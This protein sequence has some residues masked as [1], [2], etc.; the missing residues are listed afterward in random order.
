MKKTYAKFAFMRDTRTCIIAGFFL[1]SDSKTLLSLNWCS[2]K[3]AVFQLLFPLG[4]TIC[5]R[6]YESSRLPAL[7]GFQC[8]LLAVSVQIHNSTKANPIFHL[9]FQPFREAPSTLTLLLLHIGS[10]FVWRLLL[11]QLILFKKEF[12]IFSDGI[13]IVPQL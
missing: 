4:V 1:L 3:K 7:S 9:F 5:K 12:N 10:A 8:C 13:A 6:F 11:F 2:R